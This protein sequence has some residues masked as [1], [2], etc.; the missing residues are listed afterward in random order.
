MYDNLVTFICY[1]VS[2][3]MFKLDEV[4]VKLIHSVLASL[5]DKETS[6]LNG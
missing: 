5:G 2:R 1:M 3:H 4:F 6:V